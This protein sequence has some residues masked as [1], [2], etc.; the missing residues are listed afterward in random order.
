MSQ[1]NKKT[2]GENNMKDDYQFCIL[3]T[4]EEFIEHEKEMFNSFSKINPDYWICRNYK[5]IDNCRF[6]SEIPYMDQLIFAIKL[7]NKIVAAVAVNLNQ[8]NLM[9][10]Q[11]VGFLINP[12]DKNKKIC[13]VL[14]FYKTD[15][16]SNDLF[17]VFKK[18]RMFKLGA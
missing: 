15:E 17:I 10:F 5:H 16:L 6:Q 18:L 8:N 3:K 14:T 11:K 12:D 4:E 1:I 2:K 9:Q 13:E 7:D